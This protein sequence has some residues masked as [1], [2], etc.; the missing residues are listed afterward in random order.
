MSDS[1]TDV[2][3]QYRVAGHWNGR[4]QET[5]WFESHEEAAEVFRHIE[6]G[7]WCQ[8]S[9]ERSDGARKLPHEDEWY[10]ETENEQ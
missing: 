3:Y 9:V 8:L 2:T 4:W 6:L 7:S 10:V 5:D 1:N